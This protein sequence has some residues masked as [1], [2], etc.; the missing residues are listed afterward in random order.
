MLPFI[1][2]HFIMLHFI[3][4][5]FKWPHTVE[6][7]V[8]RLHQ[9]NDLIKISLSSLFVNNIG[10]GLSSKQKIFCSH[11]PSPPKYEE[12]DKSLH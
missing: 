9:I 10:N 3:M 6:M 11:S 7:T 5:T 1:V 8:N 12:I 2:L 4:F